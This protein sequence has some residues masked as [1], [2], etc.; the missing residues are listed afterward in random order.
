GQIVLPGETDFDA[1]NGTICFWMRS[2][3][4]VIDGGN[5]GALLFDR[6]GGI[7]VVQQ[8]DGSLSVS[9]PG[10]MNS[11]PAAGS[12]SDGNWHHIVVEFD[13]S[14][15]GFASFYID[16][17]QAQLNSNGSDWSWTPGQPIRLGLSSDAFF[18]PYN[19]QLDDFR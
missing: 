7:S 3:G 18:R 13:Q 1:T 17:T 12:V 19:G 10:T 14:A 6:V 11:V 4:T 5:S 9:V 16:G 2:T 8:D 15:S